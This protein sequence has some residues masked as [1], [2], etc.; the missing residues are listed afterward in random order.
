VSSREPAGAILLA[1][2][3]AASRLGL[4]GRGIERNAFGRQVDSF[5]ARV[6]ADAPLNQL[7]AALIRAP[8]FRRSSPMS[9]CWRR[10]AGARRGPSWPS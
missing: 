2:G 4:L 7:D 8:R 10:R 1:R 6:E 9:R 5:E 3:A